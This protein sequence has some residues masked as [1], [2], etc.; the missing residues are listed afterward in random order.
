MTLNPAIRRIASSLPVV[1]IASLAV[2]GCSEKPAAD[3]TSGS[4]Y[5]GEMKPKSPGGGAPAGAP[6]AGA[7]TPGVPAAT[8]RGGGA[9]DN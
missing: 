8:P 2:A 3:K 9:V 1:L 7:P 6:A 4:Y 5:E